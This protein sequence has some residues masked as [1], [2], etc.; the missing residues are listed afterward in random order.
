M[1]ETLKAFHPE[2][3]IAYLTL[4]LLVLIGVYIFKNFGKKITFVALHALGGAA[5]GGI[6]GAVLVSIF[7]WIVYLLSLFTEINIWPNEVL[8][9]Y[10][11]SLGIAFALF[12]TY[13]G[14]RMGYDLMIEMNKENKKSSSSLS[15]NSKA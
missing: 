13:F 5:V 14:L 7:Y 3:I 15:K 6:F 2:M 1:S 10:Q 8:A 11:R 12:G 4:L 9:S